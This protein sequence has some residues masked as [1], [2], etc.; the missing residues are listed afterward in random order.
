MESWWEGVL[1]SSSSTIYLSKSLSTSELVVLTPSS[2]IYPT[3]ASGKVKVRAYIIL[4]PGIKVHFS[5][6]I[7]LNQVWDFFI[8][9]SMLLIIQVWTFLVYSVRKGWA[10][11]SRHNLEMKTQ[12]EDGDQPKVDAS[13]IL[14][15]AKLLAKWDTIFHSISSI[16]ALW[17]PDGNFCFQCTVK[18]M[19]TIYWFFSRSWTRNLDNLPGQGRWHHRIREC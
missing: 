1:K 6:V 2:Q 14:S 16:S 5:D 9:F 18:K 19:T 11:C 10:I 4:Q 8:F 13:A 17:F 7:C 12:S 15:P 3:T